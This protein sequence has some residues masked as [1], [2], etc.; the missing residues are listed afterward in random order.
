M[1]LFVRVG[2]LDWSLQIAKR[3]PSLW[4]YL[5]GIAML[6]SVWYVDWRVHRR[7]LNHD[8]PQLGLVPVIWLGLVMFA[9]AI[10]SADH[11]ILF[12]TITLGSIAYGVISYRLWLYRLRRQQKRGDGSK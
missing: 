2:T 5:L 12:H 3:A 1:V 11:R 8:L 6:F 9:F 7:L 4:K 10:V